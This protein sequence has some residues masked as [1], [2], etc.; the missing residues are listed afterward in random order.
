[1]LNI[2]DVAFFGRSLETFQELLQEQAMEVFERA[3]ITVPI[4]SCSL[5]LFIHN[6]TN[7]SA[8]DIARSLGYSHQLVLQKIPKLNKLGLINMHSDPLDKRRRIYAP[9]DEGIEQ[10]NRLEKVLPELEDVYKALFN[11]IGDL[12]K[13]LANLSVALKEEPLAKRIGHRK[14]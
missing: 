12:H 4:R 9:T 10:V 11:E 6:E 3:G 7:P 14:I 5:L 2:D 1:M 13:L 8:A